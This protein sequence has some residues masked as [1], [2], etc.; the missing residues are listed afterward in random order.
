ME[1]AFKAYDIRG[2]YNKDFDKAD[3]YKIGYF[4]P[5]LLNADSVLVGRDMR[6]SSNEIFEALARGISDSGAEVKDAGLTTTPMIYWATAKYGF[7]ASVQITASHNSKEYNGMKV[8]RANAMPVGLES[9]LGELKKKIADQNPEPVENKGRMTRFDFRKEYAAFQK[10][11]LKDFSGLTAAIDCSNGMAGIIIK[12]ITGNSPNFINFTPD[13]SFPNHEPNPLIEENTEGLKRLVKNKEADFGAI[14]DGDA[15]RVTFVDDKGRFVSPDL[16]IAL[17]GHHFLENR[18]EPATVIQ[19]IRT[20]K[21]VGEYLKPMGG[22]M[23]T[24]KVG[25]AFAASKLKEIDGLYGG[26]LAGHYYFRDFYYSDSGI[27]ALIHVMNILS[28]FKAEGWTFSGLIDRIKTYANSGEIN[29]TIEDKKAAMEAVKD[30]FLNIQKP[31]NFFDFDGYRIEYPEWWFN[32]RPSNTEPYLRFLAE[33][34]DEEL[35][36][37]KV[38][39]VKRVLKPFLS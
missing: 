30:H 29:F 21:S 6:H 8:S 17:L 26:E 34:K 36:Q 22:K 39:E 12:D 7:E 33:A 24:W 31:D 11:F 19:D 10:S 3:A 38:E 13:G 16:I 4:L 1:K 20:S 5:G 37:Q 28:K 25:R 9:G 35:L 14:F 27:L 23:Y 32:I 2:I 15:D 18:K